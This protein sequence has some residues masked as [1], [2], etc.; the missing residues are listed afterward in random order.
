M[1]DQ[2]TSVESASTGQQTYAESPRRGF[3][4]ILMVVS[5]VLISF[6]GLII[7]NIDADPMVINF[8]RAL[9]LTIAVML[10]LIFQYKRMAVTYIV[11]IG[12]YGI[13][14]GVM[15]SIAAVC[16]L[17]SMT[18]TTVANTLFILSA[19]PFFTAAL[20]WVFLKERLRR[21]TVIAMTVAFLG[22]TVMVGEGFGA[23]SLYGNGMAL[24]TA[25]CFAVYA[26]IVRQ[27][28][29]INMLP[30]LL[31]STAIIIVVA[32]VTRFGQLAIS[33]E[34]FLLCMFWGGVLSGSANAMFIAASRHLAAAELT[35]FML[36][37]FALG[38]IWVW[39]FLSETPS[40]LTLVGGVLVIAAVAA[41]T[42]V[43][44][45]VQRQSG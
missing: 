15:L 2:Q 28:R 31:V 8:Y 23:G 27:N 5:S 1:K 10:I 17:Q 11:G 24:V 41:R 37:E 26:V 33:W 18:N 42:L 36:L 3:A 25:F 38:P 29:Q 12:R 9:A 14:G 20:A 16:F 4:M 6:S 45:R 44:M 35:L 43:E 34:D 30:T 40:R 32:I 39:L 21:S 7:R 13:L 19:I 22:L